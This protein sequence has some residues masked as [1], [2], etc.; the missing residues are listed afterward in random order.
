MQAAQTELNRRLGDAGIPP[1]SYGIGINTG[2][3]VS[4]VVGSDVRR[5]YAVIGNSVNLG[6]RL[7]AEAAAG[8]VVLSQATFNDLT[9]QPPAYRQYTTTLKGIEGTPT[10]YRIEG[11][12]TATR[13]ESTAVEP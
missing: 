11:A 1:V 7:C 5:Q 8:E 10:L 12:S 3:L 2:D 13:D 9:E 6:A 4:A